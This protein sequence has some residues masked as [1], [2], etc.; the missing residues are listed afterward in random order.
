MVAYHYDANFILI[1]PI[2]NRQ[3][4]TL[5]VAWKLINDRLVKARVAPKSYIMDDECSDDLKTALSKVELNDQLV[6]PHIHRANKAERDIKTLKGHLKSG[7]A[8]L[9]PDFTIQE[10][11]RIIDQCELTLNLLRASRLNP[12]Y[13]LGYIYLANAII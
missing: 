2:Q 11:D 8:T 3:T 4:A 1:Q 13:R 7:L 10:W 12:N 9:Y 5:T 6:P